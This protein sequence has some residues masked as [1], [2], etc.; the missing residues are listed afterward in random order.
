MYERASGMLLWIITIMVLLACFM[1]F[2]GGK[3]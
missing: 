3:K 1:D 2:F